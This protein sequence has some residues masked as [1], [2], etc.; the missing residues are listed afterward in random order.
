MS[1]PVALVLDGQPISLEI[2]IPD[3]QVP[4]ALDG[5]ASLPI[6][7]TTCE[8]GP[9]GPAGQSA[10]VYSIL[11]PIPVGGHR[12]ITT[13]GVG[14]IRY[15]DCTD[16]ADL[17]GLLGMT[18]HAASADSLVSVQHVGIVEESTWSWN[19][20]LPV[21]IG[22]NGVPTQSIPNGATFTQIIGFPHTPTQLFLLPR[23][24]V[25]AG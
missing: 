15:A 9:T 20:S 14:G 18:L 1:I 6:T 5:F 25:V 8:R 17:F 21:Y 19:P 12:L 10:E 13:D 11:T 22:T 23:D 2:G 24:P 4:I 3:S 16:P 7:L